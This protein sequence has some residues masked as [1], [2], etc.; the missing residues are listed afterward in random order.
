MCA[1]RVGHNEMPHL[2]KP[3]EQPLAATLFYRDILA[4]LEEEFGNPKYRGY[5]V[6]KPSERHT[7]SESG[8]SVR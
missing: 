5:F 3:D 1:V 2:F 6:L 4:V 7:L 8:E